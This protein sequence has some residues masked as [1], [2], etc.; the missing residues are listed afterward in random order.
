MHASLRVGTLTDELAVRVTLVDD[1]ILT[2]PRKPACIC[3]PLEPLSRILPEGASRAKASL[4]GDWIC[5]VVREPSRATPNGPV[6]YNWLAVTAICSRDNE[7]RGLWGEAELCECTSKVLAVMVRASWFRLS[8][9]AP[10]TMLTA[11]CD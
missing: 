5:E 8:L 6:A 10:A 7:R 2:S 3:T 1:R 9:L 4:G 11:C